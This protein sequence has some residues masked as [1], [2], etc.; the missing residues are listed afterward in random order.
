MHLDLRPLPSLF[1]LLLC[2]YVVWKWTAWFR[3]KEKET[4]TW[5]AFSVLA[6]L[7]LA[8][9]S[10]GLSVF[11]FVHASITG[12]YSFYHPVELFCIRIG[13]LTALLGLVAALLG[14]GK[15]KVPVTA[16]STLNLL[17]WLVDAMAQ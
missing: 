15:L 8:T 12:G 16:I 9:A 2:S 7:G 4:V 6:G 11:L 10:T 17:L 13:S 1:F 3:S 5:R 14:R